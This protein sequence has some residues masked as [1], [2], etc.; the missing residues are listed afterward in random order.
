MVFVSLLLFYRPVF[1]RLAIAQVTNIRC[2]LYELL[3]QNFKNDYP[4][5]KYF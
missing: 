5:V 2:Y 4:V 1:D 3:K